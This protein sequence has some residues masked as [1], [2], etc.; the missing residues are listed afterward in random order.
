MLAFAVMTNAQSKAMVPTVLAAAGIVAGLFG[1]IVRVGADLEFVGPVGIE[2][3]Y[4]G[5]FENQGIILMAIAA[6]ALVMAMRGMGKLLWVCAAGVWITLLWDVIVGMT[7]SEPKDDSL[8]GQVT[9]A[10]SGEVAKY[11]SEHLGGV[12]FEF[13]SLSWGGFALLG[14]ALLM[15]WA[16]IRGR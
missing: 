12:I 13:T 2:P 3:T 11:A 7:K 10:I 8:F 1:P 4:Y 6:L 16:A 9:D 15:I 5:N 14:G